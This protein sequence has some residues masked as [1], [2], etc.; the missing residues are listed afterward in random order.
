MTT[1]YSTAYDAGEEDA[2]GIMIDFYGGRGTW[3]AMP[4][5]VRAYAVATTPVNLLDWEAAYS[6][7][8]EE[9]LGQLSSVPVCVAVG[10]R[11]HPAVVC[12]NARIAERIGHARF[13]TIPGAAHFMI[14]THPDAVSSLITQQIGQ[15]S[16]EGLTIMAS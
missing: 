4:D 1:C 9:A 13:V 5:S 12:A 2:I 3:A 6:F 11:S 14:S 7:T 15:A 16:R 8:L 10:E